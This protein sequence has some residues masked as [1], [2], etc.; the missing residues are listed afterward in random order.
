MDPNT[1]QKTICSRVPRESGATH[2]MDR[3]GDGLCQSWERKRMAAAAV[4]E[5]KK[6]KKKKVF[7]LGGLN[8]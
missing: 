6:K 3:C 4:E 7:V 1:G 2:A 5:K 8:E